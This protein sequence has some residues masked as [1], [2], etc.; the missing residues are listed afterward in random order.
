LRSLLF[1]PT[2]ADS[3]A[4]IC[5]L[6]E[7]GTAGITEEE[8]GS[9]RAFFPDNC[10]LR[11]LD[12]SHF[13]EERDESEGFLYSPSTEDWDGILAGDRFYIA[14]PWVTA[15]TPAG[16]T[17][18]TVDAGAG[19]GTGRHESTQLVIGEL[20]HC[21]RGGEA[22]VDVGCGSGVLGE[23]CRALGASVTFGCDIDA[24]AVQAA[25]RNYVS[26]CF[27]GSA[28]AI[29]ESSADILLVNISAQAIDYL[30]DELKRIAKADAP[31]VLAGFISAHTPRCFRPRRVTEKND[32]LCWV[33]TRDD[34]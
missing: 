20:E 16:R 1:K 31:V 33:G 21:V 34:F 2:L 15:A 19:F 11:A 10:D 22:V 32:W 4:L 5:Q 12:R 7:A 14:P 28:N 24:L 6:W 9:I 23:V 17:R 30:A 27:I 13:V 18:I 25:A 29:A 26:P 8:D 3:E